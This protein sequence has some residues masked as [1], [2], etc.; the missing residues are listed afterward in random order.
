MKRFYLSVCGLLLLQSGEVSAREIK[1]QVFIV[2]QAGPAIKLALAKIYVVAPE[3]LEQAE[4]ERG[5]L[6]A[7]INR[8]QQEALNLVEADRKKTV[9]DKND[10]LDLRFN[11]DFDVSIRLIKSSHAEKI[12]RV[13][14]SPPQGLVP[15]RL[16]DADGNFKVE[17]PSNAMLIIHAE[18]ERPH[19]VYRWMLSV[20]E[21]PTDG[22]PI[23]FSNHN[24][25]VPAKN[26]KI[27]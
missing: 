27:K 6:I 26:G 3:G 17:A 21:L 20:A 11:S 23:L 8:E 12:L 18:R 7:A 22:E 4:R 10:A 14:T 2:T 9:S 16:T 1:G 5:D 25:F 19:E 13:L 24:L 15:A